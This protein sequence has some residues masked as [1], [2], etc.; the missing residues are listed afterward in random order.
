MSRTD[1]DRPH[2]VTAEWWEPSH[3][4]KEHTFS[5]YWKN[6]HT[7]DLAAE[8]SLKRERRHHW[9]SPIPRRCQWVPVWTYYPHHAPGRDTL[10]AEWHGPQRR[11]VRDTGHKIRAE[12]RATSTVDTMHDVRQARHS[13]GYWD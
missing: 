7:C 8:P 12:Y 3:M 1:K 5:R 13:V 4:C 6:T 10:R 9:R 2:W 11:G